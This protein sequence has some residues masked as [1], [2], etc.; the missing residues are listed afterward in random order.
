MGL[1]T[2]RAGASKELPRWLMP[3]HA[4]NPL[5]TLEVPESPAPAAAAR[6]Q[7]PGMKRAVAPAH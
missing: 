6:A 5:K 7:H 2:A 1:M 3:A 4:T